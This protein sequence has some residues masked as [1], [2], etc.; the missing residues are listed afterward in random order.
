[1]R[2]KYKKTSINMK[3]NQELKYRIFPC[4]SDETSMYAYNRKFEHLVNIP[5]SGLRHVFQGKLSDEDAIHWL[6]EDGQD[7]KETKL[8]FQMHIFYGIRHHLHNLN[9]FPQINLWLAGRGHGVIDSSI[10]TCT[11]LYLSKWNNGSS[12]HSTYS[13]SNWSKGRYWTWEVST[14]IYSML[15]IKSFTMSQPAPTFETF[16]QCFD[17]AFLGTR[18]IVLLQASSPQRL[19]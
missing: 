15:S 19:V 11:S 18:H 4:A 7:T 1:M 17:V 13:R 10:A 8:A 5:V 16:E 3:W 6:E 2:S 9:K 14:K 12:L